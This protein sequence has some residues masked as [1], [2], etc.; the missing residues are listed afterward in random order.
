MV[1]L[2]VDVGCEVVLPLQGLI[3]FEKEKVRLEN[4]LSKVSERSE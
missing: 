1:K 4:S 3:D 2:V